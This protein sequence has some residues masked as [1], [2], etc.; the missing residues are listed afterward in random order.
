[1]DW[2]RMLRYITET[3]YGELLLRNDYL[4]PGTPTGHVRRTASTISIPS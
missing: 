4:S 3:E 2:A 1:M